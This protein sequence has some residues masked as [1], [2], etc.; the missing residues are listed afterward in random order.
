LKQSV[1]LER[2]GSR[3]WVPEIETASQ[4][5]GL[6]HQPL[7]ILNGGT[8][9]GLNLNLCAAAIACSGQAV[10]V[11]RFGRQIFHLLHLLGSLDP[12]R[13]VAH[14]SLEFRNEIL[15]AER[16][17]SAWAITSPAAVRLLFGRWCHRHD[18]EQATKHR[19]AL[20]P[21]N[22]SRLPGSSNDPFSGIEDPDRRRIIAACAK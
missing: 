8:Q 14:P 2:P 21:G 7:E 17:A 18:G 19:K 16:W 9:V 22:S 10:I 13:R 12:E 15:Q 20:D 6:R 4:L 3:G 1:F 5:L 11:P